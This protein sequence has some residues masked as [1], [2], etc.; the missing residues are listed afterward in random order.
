MSG[1]SW[2]EDLGDATQCIA[3][4]D[5]VMHRITWRRGKLILE[6]HDIEAE[7]ALV[8]LGGERCVCLDVSQL[9]ATPPPLHDVVQTG[10]A[11]S[12]Q[13]MKGLRRLRARPTAQAQFQLLIPNVPAARHAQLRRDLDEHF[14]REH[15]LSVLRLI[16]GDLRRRLLSAS[17]VAATRRGVGGYPDDRIGLTRFFADEIAPGVEW[18]LRGARRNL[19]AGAKVDFHLHL[20][21]ND[22][23]DPTV[24]GVVSRGGGSV[25]IAVQ[26]R[27]LADVWAHDLTLVDDNPVLAVK[28]RN[29]VDT[30][31]VTAICWSRARFEL[32]EPRLESIFITRDDLGFWHSASDRR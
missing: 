11:R 24:E 31:W 16:D 12:A 1:L 8:A 23:D 25:H 30:A 3:V 15:T 17:A 9:F 22:D 6:D 27:W 29:S 18:S 20:L 14:G 21:A 7:Q 26:P 28:E 5:D 10:P 19:P 32:T 4:D 13:T 2:Y